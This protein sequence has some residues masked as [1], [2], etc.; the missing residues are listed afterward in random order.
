MPYLVYIL[1]CK[2]KSLYT[3]ITNDIAKRLAAHKSGKG[4]SYTRSH[5]PL[6][7]VYTEK[8]RTKSRALKRELAIKKLSREAKFALIDAA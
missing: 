6:K 2:D 8:A 1:Q 5:P 7:I 3:G 4:G